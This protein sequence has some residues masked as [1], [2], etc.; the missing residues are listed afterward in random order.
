MSLPD[1]D[2]NGFLPA[3]VHRATLDEVV[4]RFGCSTEIRRVQAESLGWVVESAR[5][6][7]VLR[8]IVNG[9]FVADVPEPNDV[10]C[11]ILIDDSFPKDRDAELVL[12][13]GAPF[14]EMQIV[15]QAGFDL[16]VESIYASD[17]LGTP[18]GVV[19]VLL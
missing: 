5:R 16:L 15:D 4:E 2:D 19:E 9:S 13:A 6:A 8:V 12:L 18:K 3:G 1:F 17:R 7:G 10:D 11:A 14:V